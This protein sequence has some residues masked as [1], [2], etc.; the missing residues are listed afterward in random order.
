[1]VIVSP[2]CVFLHECGHGL[3]AS[4]FHARCIRLRIGT[5]KRIF[6]YKVKEYTIDLHL[7]FFAGGNIRYAGM[8]SIPNH[9]IIIALAGPVMNLLFAVISYYLYVFL[10]Y[11]VFLI[12]L[13]FNGWMFLLN[14]IPV[15]YKGRESDGYVALRTLRN[16]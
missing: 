12:S 13:F 7:L 4:Y 14:I 16:E 6:T 1:M 2:I 5:G 3:A 15:K 11:E 8:R 10:Q 9:Q